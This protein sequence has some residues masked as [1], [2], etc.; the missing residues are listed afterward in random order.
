MNASTETVGGAPYALCG[1]M[2]NEPN[3]A[4]AHMRKR[5]LRGESA[6]MGGGP[7]ANAPS[8]DASA[9]RELGARPVRMACRSG[10][11]ISRER[12][13]ARPKDGTL[14]RRCNCVTLCRGTA[15]AGAHRNGRATARGRHRTIWVRGALNLPL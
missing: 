3:P 6:R 2:K 8:G 7:H 1:T 10:L 11:G 12:P 9:T 4:G 14:C 13:P 15:R 5:R